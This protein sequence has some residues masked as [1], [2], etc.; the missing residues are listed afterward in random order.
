MILMSPSK[1]LAML[2]IHLSNACFYAGAAAPKWTSSTR[3]TA[4]AYL[5]KMAHLS[6]SRRERYVPTTSASKTDS[7]FSTISLTFRSQGQQ[8]ATSSPCSLRRVTEAL[9]SSEGSTAI[10][11]SLLSMLFMSLFWN[12]VGVRFW[13]L[14]ADRNIRCPCIP[15]RFAG[16]GKLFE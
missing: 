14:S 9:S 2:V 1:I 6:K 16:C 5:C 7:R 10:T 13:P 11:V 15:I 3:T 8:N 12:L 4:I